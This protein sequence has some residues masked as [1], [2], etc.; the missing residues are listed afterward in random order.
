[1]A[2][3]YLLAKSGVL[4][5]FDVRPPPLVGLGLAVAVLGPLLAWSAAGTA[6]VEGLPLGWLIGLQ[7][8]RLPLELVMHQAYEVG[9]MPVQMSFSGSNF[10][11]VTGI[12]AAMLAVTMAF[13]AVPS[14]LV[15]AW[16]LA[17]LALLGNIVVIS[18]VSTPLIQA[19]GPYR[20]NTWVAQPPYVWLPAVMVLTAWTGHLVIWR[21]LQVR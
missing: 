9:L 15:W 21:A 6:L 13:R 8:F 19:F 11:I 2:A 16:N 14:W 10:D 17:G 4:A 5:R 1:M 7:V 3:T 18:I 12:T 20:L